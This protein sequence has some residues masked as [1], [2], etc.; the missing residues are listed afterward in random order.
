MLYK[1][2]FGFWIALVVWLYT[3][4]VYAVGYDDGFESGTR[5]WSIAL[6]SAYG[7]GKKR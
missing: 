7:K 1:I 2:L 5:F 6:N 3:R 4:F